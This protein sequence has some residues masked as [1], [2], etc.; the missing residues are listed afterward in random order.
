MKEVWGYC[1]VSSQG[2]NLDRQIIALKELGIDE[3]HI[4]ADKAS[5]KDFD[6]PEFLSLVGTENVAPCMREGDELVVTSLDRLGRNFSEIKFW[7]HYITQTLKVNLVVLDLPILRDSIAN[8][9]L[10]K[11]LIA[12]LVFELLA[13]VGEKERESINKRQREG[14]NAAKLR[15]VKFGRHEKPM[16]ANFNEVAT[17]WQ[18]G[19]ITAVRAMNELNLSKNLFYKYIKQ[20]GFKKGE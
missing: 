13:Y 10:E 6:R 20:I 12:D 5:G 18:K 7:W 2:Q 1:R 3:R 8:S 17:R 16:P 11:K 9:T 19:E 14:I 15:G 4:K